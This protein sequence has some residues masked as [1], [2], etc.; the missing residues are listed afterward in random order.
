[1]SNELTLE[2]RA[3]S[4]ETMKH[5]HLVAKH[6]HIICKQLMDRADAHDA[7]KLEPPEVEAFTAE[8][9]NLS[10][11]TYGSPEYY[12][13]LKRIKPALDHHYARNSHHPQFHKQGINDMTLIDVVEML[14]DWKASSMRHS[15][16]CINKSI[17]VNAGRFEM[18]PQLTK[19]LENTVKLF[20]Q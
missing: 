2:E 18:S 10:A 20:Q 3:V 15:D 4:Y 5:I 12:E 17:E 7:S 19:I 14:C 13:N 6:L 8:T 16:G 1:M 11:L 9:K